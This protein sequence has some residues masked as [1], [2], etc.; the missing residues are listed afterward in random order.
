VSNKHEER[1][2]GMRL[3]QMAL[4]QNVLGLTLRFGRG[5]EG[6][7]AGDVPYRTVDGHPVY[8]IQNNEFPLEF[9]Q[10]DPKTY[11]KFGHFEHPYLM[12]GMPDCP[13]KIKV[14]VDFRFPDWY[15]LLLNAQLDVWCSGPSY[16]AWALAAWTPKVPGDSKMKAG[17]RLFHA[18]VLGMDNVPENEWT[19]ADFSPHWER[20]WAPTERCAAI[21]H[22][23]RLPPGNPL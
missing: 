7:D 13:G 9:N 21:L 16:P 6:Q 20:D 8:H 12:M 10:V 4:Q 22:Q 5:P 1:A 23:V 17:A 18:L 15:V 14:Y 3:N 2:N 19:T 11:V